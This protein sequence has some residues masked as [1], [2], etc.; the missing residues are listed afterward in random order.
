MKRI[1]DLLFPMILLLFLAYVLIIQYKNREKVI[2]KAKFHRGGIAVLIFGLLPMSLMLYSCVDEFQST[3]YFRQEYSIGMYELINDKEI[4]S[5]VDDLEGEYKEIGQWSL[6]K[7]RG[8]KLMLMYNIL[9]ASSYLI[10]FSVGRARF[11]IDGIRSL[12]NLGKW[13]E[14]KEYSFKGNEIRLLY[15]KNNRIIKFKINENEKKILDDYLKE[16]TDLEEGN[17]YEKNY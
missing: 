9:M 5:I 10:I 11:E 3:K 6:K 8:C 14:Y 4:E 7:I 16:Y 12:N 15:T 13:K 17:L 2:T 1:A